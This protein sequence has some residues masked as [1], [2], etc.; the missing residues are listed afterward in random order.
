MS[1]YRW[2]IEEFYPKYDLIPT[3]TA[4]SMFYYFG[5]DDG[6][7]DFNLSRRLK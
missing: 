1:F 3:G 2:P 5:V 7:I 6:V 4:E